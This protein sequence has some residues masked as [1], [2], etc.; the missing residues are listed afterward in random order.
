MND[1]RVKAAKR[2]RTR[3][4]VKSALYRAAR[5]FT[6]GFLSTFTLSQI[7]TPGGAHL[8]TLEKVAV[9]GAIGGGAAVLALVQRWLDAT[10]LPTLPPG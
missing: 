2:V 9:A 7:V 6:Q 8:D 10:N 1:A 3:E 5:T 4:R